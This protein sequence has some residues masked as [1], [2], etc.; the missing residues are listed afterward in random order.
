MSED[1]QEI[2]VVYF[3][4]GWRIIAGNHRWGRYAFRVDA[5]E[6]ALRVA[7]QAAARGQAVKILVHGR[8]GELHQIEFRVE[9]VATPRI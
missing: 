7:A 9:Q 5:E 1:V 2:A 6:A 3:A 8:C 4:D